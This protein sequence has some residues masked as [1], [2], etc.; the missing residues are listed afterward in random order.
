M[1]PPNAFLF[2]LI[3]LAAISVSVVFTRAVAPASSPPPLLNANRQTPQTTPSTQLPAPPLEPL[4][5]LNDA[6]SGRIAQAVERVTGFGR[7]K[8]AFV[9]INDERFVCILVDDTERYYEL[10]DGVPQWPALTR[11]GAKSPPLP[12]AKTMSIYRSE[13]KRILGQN[14]GEKIVVVLCPPEERTT[15]GFGNL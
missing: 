15:L 14:A 7:C 4:L 6:R 8:V 2:L 9:S 10:D 11:S 5:I 12:I 3:I 1:K 13:A